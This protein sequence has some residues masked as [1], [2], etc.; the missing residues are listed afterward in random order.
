M[1]Q[2]VRYRI[3]A[4]FVAA[5]RADPVLAGAKVRHNPRDPS[6]IRDGDRVVFFEDGRDGFLE[7]PA[8][9]GKRAYSFT[10]GVIR[11]GE[12][13]PEAGAD[14]DQVAADEALR[15]AFPEIS[16]ELAA[17]GAALGPLRERETTYKVEG[18]DVGGALVLTGY[19]I[20]Y[21]KPKPAR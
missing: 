7:Q 15:A 12:E 2:S 11:R 8:Q 5:L 1:T 9:Q 10:L 17:D 21:R 4:G 16:A 18:V 19:E 6:S 13:D 14:A 20:E 3:A